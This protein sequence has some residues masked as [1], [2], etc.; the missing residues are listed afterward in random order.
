MK[1]MC[2][3]TGRQS[4]PAAERDKCFWWGLRALLL[5]SVGLVV[6]DVCGLSGGRGYSETGGIMAAAVVTT[7]GALSGVS[8]WV[9]EIRVRR[10]EAQREAYDAL[11]NHLMS[12]FTGG[13]SNVDL[14]AMRAKVVL[15]ASSDVVSKL[16]EYNALLARV[17]ARAADERDGSEDVQQYSLSPEDAVDVREATVRLFVAIRSEIGMV[18]ADAG[19]VEAALF[20]DVKCG[21][22]DA[23]IVGGN[24]DRCRLVRWWL[25]VYMAACR[26]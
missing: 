5:F 12:Q 15:S 24:V 8:S 19:V 4:S 7:M 1:N 18:G 11:A 17:K 6:V 26:P 3:C 23:L 22:V 10:D 13:G 21:A 20:D 9:D 16:A 2:D 14:A 25:R